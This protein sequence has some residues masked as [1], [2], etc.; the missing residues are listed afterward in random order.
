MSWL[1]CGR[2]LRPCGAVRVRSAGSTARDSAPRVSGRS[3]G[4]EERE[5]GKRPGTTPGISSNRDN[6]KGSRHDIPRTYEPTRSHPVRLRAYH[7]SKSNLKE[8]CVESPPQCLRWMSDGIAGARRNF[9]WIHKCLNFRNELP[10]WP[11]F[12]SHFR[13]E[14]LTPREPDF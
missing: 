5:M 14:L 1:H 4:R 12:T 2:C 11:D 8:A 3:E 7:R 13:N 6:K 10:K 9:W